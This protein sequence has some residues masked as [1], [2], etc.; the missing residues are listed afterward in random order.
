MH[1][2]TYSNTSSTNTTCQSENYLFSI[3]FN[4]D[5]K[6]LNIPHLLTTFCTPCRS[7]T[8]PRG[9]HYR[10]P[11]SLPIAIIVTDIPTPR[12]C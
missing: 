12:S 4:S 6:L 11:L 2:A 7:R 3:Y 8:L 5:F 10:C 9:F 1:I